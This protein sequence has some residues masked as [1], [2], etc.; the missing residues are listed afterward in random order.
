MWGLTP[1]SPIPGCYTVLGSSNQCS[2]SFC[3]PLHCNPNTVLAE[4]QISIQNQTDCHQRAENNAWTLLVKSSRLFSSRMFPW[5]WV[6]FTQLYFYHASSGV[7]RSLSWSSYHKS[8]GGWACLSF[9]LSKSL[10]WALGSGLDS[11]WWW[12]ETGRLQTFR[13]LFTISS[14]HPQVYQTSRHTLSVAIPPC[15]QLISSE[16]MV[17][18]KCYCCLINHCFPESLHFSLLV[19]S[20]S[21]V[22]LTLF[23]LTEGG[24][25]LGSFH[26]IVGKYVSKLTSSMFMFHFSHKLPRF[27]HCRVVVSIIPIS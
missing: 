10:C 23:V 5:K 15:T 4:A 14:S 16:D 21:G 26:A 24:S 7:W 19:F 22:F 1:A 13:P 9:L 2:P 27:L 18:S 8:I 12:R 3:L 20:P 17:S 6:L 25:K 11:F